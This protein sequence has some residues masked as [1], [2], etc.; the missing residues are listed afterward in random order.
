MRRKRCCRGGAY[1]Q[2]NGDR[3]RHRGCGKGE[4][5]RRDVWRHRPL[6]LRPVRGDAAL[7]HGGCDLP[8]DAELA[9]RGVCGA[10]LLAGI[11]VLVEKPLE[12]SVALRQQILDAQK[13]SGAKL[14]VTLSLIDTIRAVDLSELVSFSSCFAQMVDPENHRAGN[15]IEAGPVSDMAPYP[16]NAAHAVFGDGPIEVAS[17]VGTRHP[18]A[19]F[20]GD[21][22]DIVAVTLRCPGSRIA[23]FV[24]SY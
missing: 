20:S 16:V 23:Q 9:S 19:G 1:R 15:R 7:R 22:D 14:M 8:R 6:R 4:G 21:F 11:H 13:A 2:L 10:A 17:A 5:R 24:V 3:V 12:V 18:E